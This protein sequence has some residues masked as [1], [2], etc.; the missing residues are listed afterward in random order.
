MNCKN[1][2]ASVP[3]YGI[4]EYCGTVFV[5]YDQFFARALRPPSIILDSEQIGKLTEEMIR[6]IDWG[7]TICG[8]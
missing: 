1:C 7:R 4:C 8:N 5:P 6:N 2:G 3:D